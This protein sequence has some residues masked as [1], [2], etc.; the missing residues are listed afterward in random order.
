MLIC[1]MRR[2]L[3]IALFCV[4][5]LQVGGA[6]VY[7]GVR[8]VVHRQEMRALLKLKPVETLTYFKLTPEAWQ[9]AQV[10]D[11]E[12]EIDGRMY[13]IAR[14]TYQHNEVHVWAER[15]EGEDNL[16]ALLHTLAT[17]HHHDKKS[18]PTLITH[19]LALIYEVPAMTKTPGR[20]FFVIAHA[21]SYLAVTDSLLSLPTTPPPQYT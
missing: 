4:L 2:W 20:I 14:V 18:V 3:G 10:E 9:R 5:L 6:Y 17:R 19:V 16:L 15:D 7:F 21:T 12:M 13:D 11:E 8:L 1:T